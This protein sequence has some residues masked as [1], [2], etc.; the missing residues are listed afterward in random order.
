[1]WVHGVHQAVLETT[2][3]IQRVDPRSLELT[4]LIDGSPHVLGVTPECLVAINERRIKLS[5]L[6]P[7][8]HAQILFRHGPEGPLAHSIRVTNWWPVSLLES[9]ST[10]SRREGSPAPSEAPR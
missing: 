4:V 1:M 10:E 9:R 3:I 6:R 7:M 5:M 2:G 8:D